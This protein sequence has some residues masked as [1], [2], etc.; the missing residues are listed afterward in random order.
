MNRELED[1]FMQFKKHTGR[2]K[3]INALAALCFSVI[4]LTGCAAGQYRAE[5]PPGIQPQQT[6]Y[7]NYANLPDLLTVLGDAVDLKLQNFY[8]N[9]P[10]KVQ[11]FTTMGEA[12][13][14]RISALGATL[15]DQVAAVLNHNPRGGMTYGWRKSPQQLRGVL[16]EVDGYLRIH[17][18]AINDRGQ[19]TSYVTNVE[20][21]EPVYRALHTCI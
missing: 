1:L 10:I 21:S 19:R 17:I 6:T 18:T 2:V 15:A 14:R 9:G 20:M 16:Q 8:S 5:I 3:M 12:P 4:T 7:H 11:P 13:G